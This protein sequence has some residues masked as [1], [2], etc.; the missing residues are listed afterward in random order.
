MSEP[1]TESVP[2]SILWDVIRYVIVAVAVGFLVWYYCIYTPVVYV[3]REHIGKTMG[4]DYIVKVAR[5]P[6]KA[7]WREVSAVIQQRLDSLDQAMST[8]RHD[9]EVCR[10]NEFS[11]TEDWFPVS[12][13]TALLVQTSLEISRLTDGTFDITIAPLV[14]HWGFGAAGSQRPSRSFEELQSATSLLKEQTGYEKLSV[15]IDPPALK[16]QIPKLEIDLSAI[17]KGF[18]VDCIATLLEERKMTDYLIEIGGEVR[19][20]GK[21]S[22]EKDWTV[23]IEKPAGTSSHEFPGLHQAF[24]LKDQSLATSGNYLQTRQV[25]DR[26]ISHIIDP[27]TGLPAHVESGADEFAAVAV[28]APACTQA[29]AWATALFVL[30]EQK[31]RELADQQGLAVL[32]LLR[33]DNEIVELPSK[34][35]KN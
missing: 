27:R 32:F 1:S 25:G 4:T 23:G 21:K 3:S 24:S 10:F 12:Q 17:G 9:S 28:L 11:S 18:A 8:Y 6:E 7:D 2:S 26:Q 16:K 13:D 31:G 14:R 33:R 5:F 30:G 15:R 35:W 34:R 19:S 20:K 29:D 22:K